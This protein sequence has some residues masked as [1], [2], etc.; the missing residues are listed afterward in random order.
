MVEGSTEYK[1]E[2]SAV[3]TTEA[4]EATEAKTDEPIGDVAT[5]TTGKRVPCKVHKPNMELK[6][7]KNPGGQECLTRRGM[8]RTTCTVCGIE[9]VAIRPAQGP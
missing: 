3:E 8:W 9:L 6:S 2:E 5:T 7:Y 1:E 4:M